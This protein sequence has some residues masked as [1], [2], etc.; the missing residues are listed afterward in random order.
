MPKS[1]KQK[2]APKQSVL[3]GWQSIARY[4]GQPDTV[5]QRWAK[6]GMPVVVNG[7]Y[8]T[9]LP[10]QI[11]RWLGRYSAAGAPTHIVQQNT[12]LLSDL[13]LGL[14]EARQRHKV[15]RVK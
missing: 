11:E 15:H 5:A 8:V 13:R 3:T 14:S 10:E 2:R 9:A 6:M 12:D 1:V 4:L 7:R